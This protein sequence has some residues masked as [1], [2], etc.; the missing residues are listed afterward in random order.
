MLVV[1]NGEV[2]NSEDEVVTLLIFQNERQDLMKA[3]TK[4]EDI[5]TSYPE[6]T[7]RKEIDANILALQEAVRGKAAEKKK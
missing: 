4:N 2:H 7:P 6:G 1:I 3:F 5:Y